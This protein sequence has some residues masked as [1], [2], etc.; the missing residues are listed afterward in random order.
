MLLMVQNWLK[1]QRA[2]ATPT[3]P[4]AARRALSMAFTST[5]RPTVEASPEVHRVH[6][7]S[8]Q[9]INSATL[10]LERGF[11]IHAP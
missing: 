9:V 5:D 6:R 10:L 4:R 1:S 2:M 3:T 11:L 7:Q 8:Y